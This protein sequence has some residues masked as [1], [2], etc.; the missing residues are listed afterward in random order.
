MRVE[1]LLGAD[2]RDN[3]WSM[4]SIFP[5]KESAIMAEFTHKVRRSESCQNTER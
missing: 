1:E 3:G 4:E 5:D 2:I